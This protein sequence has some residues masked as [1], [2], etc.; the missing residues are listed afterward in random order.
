MGQSP[1]PVE[2]KGG[3]SIWVWVV[4]VVVVLLVVYFALYG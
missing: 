1:T 2:S 3:K 4:I